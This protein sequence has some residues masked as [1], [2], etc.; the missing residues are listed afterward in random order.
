M[1]TTYRFSII[2]LLS[3]F[4]FISASP[5]DS[6][7]GKWQNPEGTACFDFYKAG[8]EYRARQLGLSHPDLID[9]LNPVDSLKSRKMY[10]ATV[11]SGLV[12]NAKKNRWEK[13]TVYDCENGKTYSCLCTITDNG[14]KL[15]MRGYLGIS[16]L[17]ITKNWVRPTVETRRKIERIEAVARK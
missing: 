10:G 11:L 3:H 9:T 15:R 1:K 5:G 12:F 8:N 4:Y 7:L 6:I 17:G 2:I 16:V 14:Q 13:G